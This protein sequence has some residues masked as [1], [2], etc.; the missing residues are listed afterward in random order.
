VVSFTQI[1]GGALPGVDA[2]V[3]LDSTPEISP[4]KTAE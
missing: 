1:G 4:G 3:Q 2:A